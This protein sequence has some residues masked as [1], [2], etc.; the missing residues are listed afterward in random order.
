MSFAVWFVI[1][2]IALLVVGCIAGSILSKKCEKC[3]R[4]GMEL[5]SEREADRYNSTKTVKD[6]MKNKKGEVIG[7]VE[8]EVPVTMIVYSCLYRCKFCGHEEERKVTRE[9]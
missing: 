4:I 2:I 6:S 1:I 9:K 3:K 5:V 7:Y 8:K